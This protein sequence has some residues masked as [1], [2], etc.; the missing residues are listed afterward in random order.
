MEV[1]GLSFRRQVD[2]LKRELA[3]AIERQAATSEILR[4]ISSSPDDVQ[5]V[6]DAIAESA[7]RLCGA[8]FCFVFRFDGALLHPAAYHG[9]SREGIEAVRAKFPQQPNRGNV[10]GRAFVSGMVEQIPDVFTDPDYQMLPL[11]KI[12]AYRSAIGRAA[13]VEG[14]SDR[15][16]SRHSTGRRMLS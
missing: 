6:F 16:D 4:V 13:L 7:A 10:T 8:E 9:I 11:A 5:P 2:L 3:D 12:V 14:A 15:S 1:S